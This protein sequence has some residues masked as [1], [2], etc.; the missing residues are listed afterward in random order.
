MA[1]LRC[2]NAAA[3]QVLFYVDA[4]CCMD[5]G[6][7]WLGGLFQDWVDYGMVIRLDIQHWL[8]HW[9]AVVIKKTHAKYGLFINALAGAVLAYN[10]QD[11]TTLIRAM[12]QS[13]EALYGSLSDD[14]IMSLLKPYQLKQYVQRVTR[15]DSRG[16]GADL[17]RVQGSSWAGH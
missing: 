6:T 15:G 3:P 8:H 14:H 17:G 12:R 2:E 1:W 9:D 16:S 13:N 5:G 10:K 4:H 11:M 7:S